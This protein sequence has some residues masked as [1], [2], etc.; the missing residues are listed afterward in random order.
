MTA[1][2][3]PRPAVGKAEK[4]L[5]CAHCGCEPIEQHHEP[6]THSS[7]LKNAIPD[8]PDHQ[9]SYTVECPHC[10][11]GMIDDFRASLLS[12]WN[13]RTPIP[14]ADNGR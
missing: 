9:G 11:A 4:M 14:G 7:W 10:G 2:A 8:L 6:H 1:H 12:R 3:D 13:R 5:P